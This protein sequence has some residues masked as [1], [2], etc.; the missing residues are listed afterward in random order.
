MLCPPRARINSRSFKVNHRSDVERVAPLYTPAPVS[1]DASLTDS[2]TRCNGG[3]PDLTRTKR[4]LPVAE[5]YDGPVSGQLDDLE[6]VPAESE[7]EDATF[8][9]GVLADGILCPR[10]GVKG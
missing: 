1:V 2:R 10:M 5:A 7:E 6:L 9:R 4:T 3:L 8:T